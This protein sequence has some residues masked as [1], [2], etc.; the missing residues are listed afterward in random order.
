MYVK[1]TTFC[2]GCGKPCAETTCPN[3]GC[4]YMTEVQPTP[5]ELCE[6]CPVEDSCKAFREEKAQS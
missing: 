4:V 2:V 1:V 5:E 3:C 6:D